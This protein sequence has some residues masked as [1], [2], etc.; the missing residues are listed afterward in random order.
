[1]A[2]DIVFEFDSLCYGNN[3]K[4]NSTNEPCS[5][6]IHP[7]PQPYPSPSLRIDKVALHH[8]PFGATSLSDQTIGNAMEQVYKRISTRLL[9][10]I[11]AQKTGILAWRE[12]A[13]AIPGLDRLRVGTLVS[14]SL[15]LIYVGVERGAVV[16]DARSW[17]VQVA[18]G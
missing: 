9:F 1:M 15:L 2:Q 4:N 18:R 6:P 11:Q 8:S 5:D 14:V 16:W 17:R 7:R 12:Q 13:H 10:H 3:N